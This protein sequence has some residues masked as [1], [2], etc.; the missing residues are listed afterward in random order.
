MLIIRRTNFKF[1]YISEFE[2]LYEKYV[3]SKS[4]DQLGSIDEKTSGK[5]LTQVY[6]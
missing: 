2:S 1:E 5:N 6:L 4:G 3:G